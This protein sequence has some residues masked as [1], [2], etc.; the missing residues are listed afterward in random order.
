MLHYLLPTP[1]LAVLVLLWNGQVRVRVLLAPSCP[2]HK[3]TM[4][5]VLQVPIVHDY[6]HY[7]SHRFAHP[8]TK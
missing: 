7:P 8:S 4:P 6:E 3:L 2:S 1:I 5:T